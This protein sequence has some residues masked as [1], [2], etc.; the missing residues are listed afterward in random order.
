MD[1]ERIRT[2]TSV[3]Q[4]RSS[5]VLFYGTGREEDTRPE[6]RRGG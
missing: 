4:L 3:L 2:W 6:D 5:L 1:E